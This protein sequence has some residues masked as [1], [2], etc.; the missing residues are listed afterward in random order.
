MGRRGRGLGD[1]WPDESVTVWTRGPAR[2]PI[3]PPPYPLDRE[4][5]ASLAREWPAERF[6]GAEFSTAP[7]TTQTFGPGLGRPL[8]QPPSA[9]PRVRLTRP[10]TGTLG[11]TTRRFT[12]ELNV[13]AF[14]A[15]PVTGPFG[16]RPLTGPFGRPTNPVLGQRLGAGGLGQR[17]V[18]GDLGQRRLT[19][20]LQWQYPYAASAPRAGVT[21]GGYLILALIVVAMVALLFA[22]N[23]LPG[24]LPP[25][26]DIMGSFGN[27]ASAQA[28]ASAQAGTSKLPA[29]LL[30]S[31]RQEFEALY[32]RSTGQSGDDERYEVFIS[33]RPVLLM[34][35]WGQGVDQRMRAFAL[36][37]GP[38]APA[39]GPWDAATADTICNTFLPTDVTLTGAT[40]GDGYTEYVYASAALARVFPA[41]YFV[42][43]AYKPVPIGTLNRLDHVQPGGE[44]GVAA[45]TITLGRH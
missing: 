1:A 16:T 32:G 18:T 30:G 23:V 39:A 31:G 20:P 6:V 40:H 5:D 25:L 15:R 43:D 44:T 36:T 19:G 41:T 11:R 10:L 4:S 17:P 28:T 34:V 22:T 21:R 45:C 29:P 9:D 38:R 35:K 37:A 14:G 3:L 42:D 24:V 13:G 2:L 27:S 12:G 33:G 8:R 7:V 26:S